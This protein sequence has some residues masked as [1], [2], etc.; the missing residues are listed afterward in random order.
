MCMFKLKSKLKSYIKL[1]IWYVTLN[2]TYMIWYINVTYM[3]KYVTLNVTYMIW[4][5]IW[6]VTLNL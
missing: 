5:M 2:V 6:Y 4:Y 3:I 1:K